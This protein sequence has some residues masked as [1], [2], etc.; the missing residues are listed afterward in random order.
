ME[1][2]IVFR[3][4]PEYAVALRLFFFDLMTGAIVAPYAGLTFHS[5]TTLLRPQ[6]ITCAQ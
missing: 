3:C 5:L 4:M 1:S 6:K 2:S